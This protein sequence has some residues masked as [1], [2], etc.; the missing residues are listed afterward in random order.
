MWHIFRWYAEEKDYDY[1]KNKFVSNAGNF[2]QLVWAN[3]KEMGLGWAKSNTGW[4]YV[5]ARFNPTGNI[6]VTPPGEEECMKENV[7]KPNR[8][9]AKSLKKQME[10]LNFHTPTKD[11]ISSFVAELN[12]K[13]FSKLRWSASGLSR[14][15]CHILTAAFWLPRSNCRVWTAAYGLPPP[16]IR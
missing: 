14:S 8:R 11:E 15:D 10:Q 7:K 4:T 2:T 9:E 6:V 3:T 16:Y 12:R 5:C 1:K 13:Q